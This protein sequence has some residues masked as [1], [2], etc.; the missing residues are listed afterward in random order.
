MLISIYLIC[1]IKIKNK[2]I[3]NEF[4]FAKKILEV[5]FNESLSSKE[6]KESRFYYKNL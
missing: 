2:R 4:N 6:L 5:F 3:N 1:Y